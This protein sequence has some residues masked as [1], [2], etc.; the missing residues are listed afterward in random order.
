MPDIDLF[1][2]EPTQRSLVD[3]EVLFDRGDAATA[4]YAVLAGSVEITAGGR[5]LEIVEP[6]GILGEVALL[7]DRHRTATARA[8]GE[9][10]VAVVDEARFLTLVRMNPY[11]ALE[12]MRLLASRLERATPSDPD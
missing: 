2:N 5:V 7:G 1:R 12:V 3:D 11:F 9:T 4:F 6:G 10:V 8:A